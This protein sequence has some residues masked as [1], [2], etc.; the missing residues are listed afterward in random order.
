[1]TYPHVVLHCA[2]GMHR[3]G[4]AAFCG[5]RRCGF[6]ATDA[7]E[8]IELIRPITHAELLKVEK[9]FEKPLWVIADELLCKDLMHV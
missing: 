2:A 4:T 7:L 5:L 8:A 3:T 9:R 6:S 1:M